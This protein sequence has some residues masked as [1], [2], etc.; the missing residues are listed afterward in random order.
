MR[1]QREDIQTDGQTDRNR[2]GQTDRQTD[3]Q[4]E[5]ERERGRQTKRQTKQA[6]KGVENT[7]CK[8]YTRSDCSFVTRESLKN[9]SATCKVLRAVFQGPHE[10]ISSLPPL[11]LALSAAASPT[12]LPSSYGGML[13]SSIGNNHIDNDGDDVDDDDDIIII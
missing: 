12:S 10:T 2:D 8:N 3:R 13:A 5:R 4:T 1:E 6:E 7:T 11:S 9:Q